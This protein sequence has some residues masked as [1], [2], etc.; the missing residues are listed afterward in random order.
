M[1]IGLLAGGIPILLHLLNRIHSPVVPFPTL[2]FLKITAMKTSRRRQLQ[3]WVLLFLRVAL[4]GLIA[5]ALAQ[6]FIGGGSPLLAYGLIGLFLGG[7]AVLVL[8]VTLATAHGERSGPPPAEGPGGLATSAARGRRAGLAGI[9][10]LIVLACAALGYAAFGLASDHYFTGTTGSYSGRSTACVI[11]FDNSHS[12]LTRQD[13]ASRL[14]QAKEQLRTLLT[15]SAAPAEVALLVTNPGEGA[16]PEQWTSDTT[17]VLGYVEG[18]QSQ[19][20]ARPMRQLVEQAAALLQE[21]AQPHRMLLILSDLARP[22]FA[23]PG[24]F[25]PLREAAGRLKEMQVVLMTLG[26]SVNDVG[27][28]RFALGAGQPVVGSEVTLEGQLVNNGDG[29]VVAELELLV[30]DQAAPGV[31]P[32][33]QIGPAGGGGRAAVRIPYRLASAGTHRLTL[34]LKEAGDALAWDDQRQLVLNVADQIQALVVGGEET[35]R[36]RTAAHYVATALN[37]FGS[38]A[39]LRGED[40]A[41]NPWSIAPTYRS[42]GRAGSEALDRY[43]AVFLCDVPRISPALA[44]AL[45]RYAQRGHRVVWLL[46]PSISA[47]DYNDQLA[48]T[49]ELLPGPLA[50]PVV[51]AAG[52]VLDW[53]DPE[54]RVFS[55]LFDTPEPFRTVVVAGRWGL[56]KDLPLRG[57]TIARLAD[58]AVFMTQHTLGRGEIFTLFSAP[59]GEWSTMATTVTFLPLVNRMALGD[60]GR[61]VAETSFESGQEVELPAGAEHRATA[62][63]VLTPRGVTINVRASGEGESQWR[64]RQTLAD[65]LYQWQTIDQKVRGQ[66]V[67]NPPAEEA[68]LTP[69][70]VETLAKES[71]VVQPT[72]VAPTVGELIRQLDQQAQP[73]SL[74]PGVLAVVM[75]LLILE[76]LLANRYRPA[77]READV[78]GM[79]REAAP[80][81]RRDAA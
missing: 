60:I 25:A 29:A 30:D 16:A 54:A 57:R 34:Q 28:A 5:M 39:A 45:A 3:Q 24:L 8:G 21:S 23:D 1:L 33:V 59:S 44:D 61:T 70:D 68:D 13:S 14:Q 52:S 48:E 75:M 56:E 53:V 69:A 17:A 15:G 49:R 36:P 10:G 62:V 32:R 47:K 79:G 77:V 31:H 4:F 51:S 11:I 73:Y 2:R 19:G 80:A 58:G 66:F 40:A 55:D 78:P 65:G 12:M 72:L 35:L 26:G 41:R 20:R 37:P 43:A 22:A 18:V 42:A 67:V 27:V 7:A 71:S 64:F 6:P 50:A 76:A 46:G 38:G 9:F 81:A 74:L 63:D